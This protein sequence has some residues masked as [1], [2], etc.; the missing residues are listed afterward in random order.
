MKFEWARERE[1]S[2]T[3]RVGLPI[4]GLYLRSREISTSKLLEMLSDWLRTNYQVLIACIF[5]QRE[6]ILI[7]SIT[8]Q[9]EFVKKGDPAVMGTTKLDAGMAAI[10]LQRPRIKLPLDATAE[11]LPSAQP[12]L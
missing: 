1:A 10:E 2:T 12:T 5:L 11:R 3:G 6:L 8:G 9:Y 4:I 7:S